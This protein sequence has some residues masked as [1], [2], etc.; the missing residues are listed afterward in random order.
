MVGSRE[1]EPDSIVL[2]SCTDTSGL[3][4]RV[5]GLGFRVL[6]FRVSGLGFRV[7]GFRG[8]GIPCRKVGCLEC[9]APLS[10]PLY[11]PFG[12]P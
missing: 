12:F 7:L 6:G 5:Q 1:V 11:F 3:G 9:M 2:P 10:H 4:F 8:S